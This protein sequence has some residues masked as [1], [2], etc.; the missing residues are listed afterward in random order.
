MSCHDTL[1]A[2]KEQRRAAVGRR[3][4]GEREAQQDKQRMEPLHELP[5][6]AAF[7]VVDR[8]RTRA[9]ADLAPTI[10][11]TKC[12]HVLRRVWVAA[13]ELCTR[14]SPFHASR[15]VRFMHLAHVH[16]FEA[17]HA[18]VLTILAARR[19]PAILWRVVTIIVDAIK[20]MF[21]WPE[22]HVRHESPERY[23]PSSAY[24]NPTA[25]VILVSLVVAVIAALF[26]RAPNA[27]ERM[28]AVSI[29]YFGGYADA[30]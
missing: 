28:P 1:Q 14:S 3:C 24:A 7:A 4:V 11:F 23:F 18:S 27:I 21:Q 30:F 5:L 8:K 17:R 25:A 16:Q 6:G 12:V 29:F 2:E 26:H 10:Y 13:L 22:P 9:R 20:F 15:S 19:P